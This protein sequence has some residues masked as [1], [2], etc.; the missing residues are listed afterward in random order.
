MLLHPDLLLAL[1]NERHRELIA[2]ADQERLLTIARRVRR[3][4]RA[5]KTPAARGEPT[6]TLAA[7]KPSAAAP[8]Q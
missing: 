8:A 6:G 1:A 3:G 2:E 4:R 7:C 5:R